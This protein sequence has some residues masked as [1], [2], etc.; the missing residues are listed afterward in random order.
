MNT[1]N[2]NM[3]SQCGQVKLKDADEEII[4]LSKNGQEWVKDFTPQMYITDETE[5]NMHNPTLLCKGYCWIIKKEY[6]MTPEPPEGWGG[7]Q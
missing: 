3:A 5:F 4:R 2:V 7:S 1:V 6:L